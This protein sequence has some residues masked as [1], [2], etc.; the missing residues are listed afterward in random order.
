MSKVLLRLGAAA[1][2]PARRSKST[3]CSKLWPGR[4]HE[5]RS[6]HAGAV[7][8]DA[9]CID[10]L[11]VAGCREMCS[12]W[13]RGNL[14][15]IGVRHRHRCLYARLCILSS[16]PWCAR[17]KRFAR[18]VSSCPLIKQRVRPV[19]LAN[20]ASCRPIHL[21]PTF[22]IATPNSR[23]SSPNT[24]CSPSTTLL[25]LRYPFRCNMRCWPN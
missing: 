2:R 22:K 9:Q 24:V 18:S 1:G 3:C 16:H 23:V 13:H 21:Q 6:S 25:T 14:T 19:C 4:A 5:D 7:Q 12:D 10:P 20:Q 11:D 8:L 17:A 15:S